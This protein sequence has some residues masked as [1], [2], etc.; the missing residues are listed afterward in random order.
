MLDAS[1]SFTSFASEYRRDHRIDADLLITP[2]V[3]EA[4]RLYLSN[5][6]I[7]PDSSEWSAY[8]TWIEER[9]RQE[10]MTLEFGVAKGD[11]VE[12]RLDTVVRRA[13]KLLGGEI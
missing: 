5:R 11:E 1:G 3:L 9:L 2:D 7:R 10:L 8:R 4:F 12:A 6:E 13:V